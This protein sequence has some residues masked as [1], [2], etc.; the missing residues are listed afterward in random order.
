M[1]S[2]HEVFQI[3]R[4]FSIII[5]RGAEQQ[6][7]VVDDI[8]DSLGNYILAVVPD[9]NLDSVTITVNSLEV[10]HFKSIE[11]LQLDDKDV[12]LL[13]TTVLQTEFCGRCYQMI[14]KCLSR[15]NSFFLR[16]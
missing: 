15:S 1:L 13:A 8:H 6:A 5:E 16:V 4:Q 12:T 10:E 9:L 7:I 14:L 3:Q 2:F 11:D